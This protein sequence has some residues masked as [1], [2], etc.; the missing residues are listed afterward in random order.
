MTL[1]MIPTLLMILGVWTGIRDL[2]RK[3]WDDTLVTML[4]TSAAMAAIIIQGT[5]SVPTQAAVKATYLMPAS[6]AFSFW[7]AL[8]I[9]RLSKSR[10]AW[11]WPITGL[12]TALALLSAAV[13][14][15]GLFIDNAWML[16]KEGNGPPFCNLHGIV[17]YAAG[18]RQH[19]R[20]LFIRSA[21][22]RWPQA[23]ENL[24]VL[25]SQDGDAKDALG[26]MEQAS[27]I[28]RTDLAAASEVD[29]LYV[30]QT[31][32]EYANTRGVLH[33]QLG[34][35][36]DALAALRESRD[37]EPSIPETFY[38][39]GV[40]NLIEALAQNGAQRA[41]LVEE[42]R[43]NFETSFRIDPAFYEA[44]AMQGVAN[45]LAGD[46]ETGKSLIREALAPHPGV[47]RAYPLE[48]GPGDL[49]SAGLNRRQRIE[50]LPAELDPVTRLNACMQ[51][52][53]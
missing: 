23:F 5:R 53:A 16:P 45:A 48:T 14:T 46:C 32:A 9:D 35:Y 40:L 37:L 24:A 38:N 12:C 18:D 20:Q 1:G 2:R 50:H 43:R 44:L 51:V 22:G 29:R 27:R 33:Y 17:Y 21:Q 8:G 41:T 39:L 10:P 19:A 31:L 13:F 34:E 47:F 30:Q 6:V 42:A 15:H 3:G 49:H 28:K 36:S 25:V 7:F 4:L 26:L 52:G 11:L